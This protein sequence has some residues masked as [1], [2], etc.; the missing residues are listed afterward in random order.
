MLSI[1]A[2]EIPA[3]LHDSAF[4]RSLLDSATDDNND[5]HHDGKNEELGEV[6]SIPHN[7]MKLDIKINSAADLRNLLSTLRFWG[8]E[9]IPDSLL[10]YTLSGARNHGESAAIMKEFENVVFV[11][12]LQSESNDENRMTLAME[13]GSL[14]FIRHLHKYGCRFTSEGIF[15]AALNG[16]THC[17]RFAHECGYAQWDSDGRLCIIAVSH[18]DLDCLKF[19]H[20]CGCDWNKMCC[21]NAVCRGSVECL[22]YLIEN[23]CE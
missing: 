18:D 13:L 5:D 20:E 10:D 7:C 6:I 16:H 22:R 15:L 14:V 8:S 21:I 17:L 12:K 1:R 4:Y 11:Q 19:L 23:G 2:P 3:Y 9:L